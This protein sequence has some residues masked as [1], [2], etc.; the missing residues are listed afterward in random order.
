MWQCVVNDAYCD[1]SPCFLSGESMVTG[2]HGW[3]LQAIVLEGA[4]AVVRQRFLVTRRTVIMMVKQNNT[5]FV[6]ID[7]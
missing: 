5:E 4:S 2:F 7:V 3:G 1:E 6:P